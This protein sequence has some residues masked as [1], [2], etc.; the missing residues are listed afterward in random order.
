MAS[1]RIATRGSAQAVTQAE[2]VAVALRANGHDVEPVLIETH[3]AVRNAW[4]L[5]NVWIAPWGSWGIYTTTG[6]TTL[7]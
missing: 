5:A 3:G 6:T 1:V 4:V 2:H 7:A